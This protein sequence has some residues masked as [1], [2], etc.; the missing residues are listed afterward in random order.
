MNARSKILLKQA[1]M[2]ALHNKYVR[3]MEAGRREIEK[4]AAAEMAKQAMYRKVIAGLKGLGKEA[5]TQ[6]QPPSVARA[7]VSP[8]A[9][10]RRNT[11]QQVQQARQE[12]RS[13][14]PNNPTQPHKV[15]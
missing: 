1:Q 2:L 14:L 10:K 13:M 9:R 4:I 6:A 12:Y 5:Q 11:M 8:A 7:V 15:G 3:A